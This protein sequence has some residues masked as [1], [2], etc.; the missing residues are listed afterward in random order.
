MQLLCQGHQPSGVFLGKG[1]LFDIDI[2]F[3]SAR[4]VYSTTTCKVQMPGT[5]AGSHVL[6]TLKAAAQSCWWQYMSM[7][8]LGLSAL[9][10]SSS[11]SPNL[12]ML[13]CD[14]PQ[15]QNQHERNDIRQHQQKHTARPAS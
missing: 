3:L 5:L 12:P 8:S 7:A 14:V 13:Q 9:T 11:A 10:N 4:E 15:Y 6:A 2:C 1:P